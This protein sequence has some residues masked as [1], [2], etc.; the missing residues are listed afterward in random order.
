LLLSLLA[1][2]LA[3]ER[4]RALA[5]EAAAERESGA[6]AAVATF[7]TELFEEANPERA[8]GASLT[9]VALVDR[10]LER[11]VGRD[12]LSPREQARLLATLGA[13]Y[14]NLGQPLKAT[15][16]LEQAVALADG[17][18][19]DPVQ[20][21]SYLGALGAALGRREEYGAAEQAYARAMALAREAG[22]A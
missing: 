1:W 17:S 3:D 2:R 12:D 8:R 10:G 5:A 9:P 20:Q 21:A 19:T 13:V 6:A 18:G 14:S 4:D 22:D 16:V 15:Q 7:L 11:L